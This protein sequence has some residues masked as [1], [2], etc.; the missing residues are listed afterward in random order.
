MVV[1]YSTQNRVLDAFT[2][3][4]YKTSWASTRFLSSLIGKEVFCYF[5]RDHVEWYES[6]FAI[7]QRIA[8]T[9]RDDDYFFRDYTL[10]K[11]PHSVSWE[12]VLLRTKKNG[13]KFNP[14][15]D[16]IFK[17]VS[18]EETIESEAR[19]I[20]PTHFLHTVDSDT[21][22]P[23]RQDPVRS[24]K[25]SN[26]SSTLPNIKCRA[27]VASTGYQCANPPKPEYR[28][29]CGVHKNQLRP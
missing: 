10:Y 24:Y 14:K 12:I 13:R 5:A 16:H 17:L 1:L 6:D 21:G 19:R 18:I 28:G 4:K 25:G 8:I 7:H 23:S 29:Y 2:T 9:F 22:S 20:Y 15:F 27:I 3:P 11:V 26:R